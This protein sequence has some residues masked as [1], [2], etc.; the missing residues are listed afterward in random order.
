MS[1]AD[2]GPLSRI[3]VPATHAGLI[4]SDLAS[5]KKSGYVFVYIPGPAGAGGHITSYTITARPTCKGIRNY[6]TDESGVIRW[7]DQD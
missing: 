1:L 3:D 4:G 2:L 5:G 6:L 7:T